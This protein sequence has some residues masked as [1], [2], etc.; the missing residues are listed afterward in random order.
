[1]PG[2]GPGGLLARAAAPVLARATG[3]LDGLRVGLVLADRDAL[4]VDVP[5]AAPA[6]RRSFEDFGLVRGL[7]LAE[8]LLGPNAVGTP[9]VTRTGQLV[10]GTEHFAPVFHAFAC[11]G[12]PIVH[13]LTRRLE[14]VLTITGLLA[15][16]DRL[17]IPF[18]RR[19]AGEI[20]ARLQTMSTNPQ[21]LLLEA[22]QAAGRARK[23]P[24]LAVG[25][26]LALATPAALDLLGPAD[27]AVVRAAAE[28]GV[29]TQDVRLVSG[30]RVRLSCTP[31][32][33]A[34]G[35]LVEILP[36][37]RV[38]SARD[39]VSAWPLLVVGETGTGRTT[40]AA[41]AA[42]PGAVTIDA[43]EVVAQGEQR[44]A[45]RAGRLL[46]GDG[47]PAIL[48]NIQL[49]SEPVTALLAAALDRSDR[50]VVLTTTPGAHLSGPHAPLAARCR[51][52]REL[53]PL[54]LRQHDIPRLAEGMLAGLGEPGQR[55]LTGEA[56]RVLAAQ[57]WPGNLVELR[58]VVEAVAAA[59]S[60]G[61]VVVGDLPETHRGTGAPASP[62]RQA[63]REMITAAIDA[64]GGNKLRA[65]RSLGMSRSTLYNRMRA[66]SIH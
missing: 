38:R 33:G 39:E 8:D 45:E 56:L 44:W 17:M 15:E 2:T 53:V 6:I 11:Y 59:C 43:V 58:S 47:A 52:R 29:A 46:A 50:R 49:V 54:R 61:D 35:V 14:G 62:L 60:A 4:V 64:A 55:R 57:P 13:P 19:I 48:E 20:E 28:Q 27:H 3:E 21:H 63:E 16:D 42:G 40:R 30:R 24:V 18:A 41:E 37:E 32:D 65:A 1:M 25:P 31:V 36:L 7:C 23:R 51:A 26:G 12:E 5:F 9:L 22:F 10:R 66:L 34:D